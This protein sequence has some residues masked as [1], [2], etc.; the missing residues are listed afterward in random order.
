MDLDAYTA[1]HSAE[2]QRLA[3]LGQQR[4]FT[5]AEADELIDRYQSGATQMSAI[6]TTTAQSIQGD[7]LSIALSRVRLRF[8]GAAANVLQRLPRF[9]LL[10]LP[11]A[12]Y[13]VRW[14]TIG[15]AVGT[16]VIALLWAWYASTNPDLIASMLSEDDRRQLAEEDFI[17]YYSEH[18]EGTF[19]VMVWANNAF[20]AALCLATG[21]LFGIWPIVMLT[22]NAQSLGLTATIMHEFG[23][24]G[25]FFLYIAPHGQ[26]ELY[27]V[28]LAGATGIFIGWSWIIPGHRKRSVAL[29]ED[30][31]AFFT[32]AI[33]CAIGLAVS[34]V[35][36]GFVTRQDWPWP[37]KIGIGT[38]ALAAFVLYQWVVGRRAFRAGETGDL[39][40]FEAGARELVAG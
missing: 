20:I 37:I 36:E 31:R 35:I 30:G 23:H 14:L 1:A 8:T 3:E 39:E 24:L 4:S 28:F 5:G 18:G 6:A 38:V 21:I 26:L 12:L 25:D 2:W 33:G 34:G 9:F 17:A 19:S 27:M 29:A 32:I 16:T 10:Q 11:A 40:E 22:T 7:R 15:V 13:R